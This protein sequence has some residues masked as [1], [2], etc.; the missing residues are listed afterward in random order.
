LVLRVSCK[1][2]DF[3]KIQQNFAIPIKSVNMHN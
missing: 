3:S 2:A 1:I